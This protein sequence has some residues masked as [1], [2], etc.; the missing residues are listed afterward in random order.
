VGEEGLRGGGEE[1]EGAAAD[2]ETGVG[3][4]TGC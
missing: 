3:L 4:A 1:E 2:S